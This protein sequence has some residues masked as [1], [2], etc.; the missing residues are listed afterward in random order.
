MNLGVTA[1]HIGVNKRDLTF[2]EASDADHLFVKHKAFTSGQN[3]RTR[4]RTTLA[5]AES[6]FNRERARALV[7]IDNQLHLDRAQK[8]VGLVTSMFTGG[9]AEFASER[10]SNVDE[11]I[12]IVGG[13]GDGEGVWR[14]RAAP[15]IDGA[16]IVHLSSEFATDLDRA[17]TALEDSG[18]HAFNG[19]FETAFETFETHGE[20]VRAAGLLGDAGRFLQWRWKFCSCTGFVSTDRGQ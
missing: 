19:M 10:I 1:A 7:V 5:F 9:V 8:C 12:V 6:R 2:G 17:D 4:T 18:E 14:D 11:G 16:V 20:Q 15:D 3:E 13:N